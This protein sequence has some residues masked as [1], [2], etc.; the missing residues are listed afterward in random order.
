MI[1]K[2]EVPDTYDNS[3]EIDSVLG[4]MPTIKRKGEGGAC[5]LAKR[6]ADNFHNK[7]LR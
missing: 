5:S 4:P 2:R 3:E 1:L 6:I 7:F